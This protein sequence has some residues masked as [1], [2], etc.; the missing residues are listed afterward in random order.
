MDDVTFLETLWAVP[1]HEP[2]AESTA[3]HAAAQPT[4]PEPIAAYA[5]PVA[6]PQRPMDGVQRQGDVLVIPVRVLSSA[7][8]ARVHDLEAS[9]P[10]PVGA[11]RVPVVSGAHRHAH[12]HCLVGWGGPS[13]AP[14]GG[15]DEVTDATVGVLTVPDG[16]VAHLVHTGHHAPL[17]IAP[18]RYVLRRQRTHTPTPIEPATPIERG[19]LSDRPRRPGPAGSQG[20]SRWRTVWD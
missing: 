20:R 8:R 10:V 18:G 6:G 11:E 19:A 2:T 14:V 13:W 15:A 7:A 17:T 12:Q 4:P 16:A 3:G 1:A 9:G 5:P